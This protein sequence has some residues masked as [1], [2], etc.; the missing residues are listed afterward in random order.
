MVASWCC[1]SGTVERSDDVQLWISVTPKVIDASVWRC[2]RSGRSRTLHLRR[3][4]GDDPRFDGSTGH[5]AVTR[6]LHEAKYSPPHDLATLS[7][8]RPSRGCRQH[9]RRGMEARR[10]TEPWGQHLGPVLRQ[11]HGGPSVRRQA[12]H[13]AP[14]LF[15]VSGVPPGGRRSRGRSRAHLSDPGGRL[16]GPGLR[17][18]GQRRFFPPGL[19]AIR[20][21]DLAGE[22]GSTSSRPRNSSAAWSTAMARAPT[23]SGGPSFGTTR[24]SPPCC[25]PAPTSWKGDRRC[26]AFPRLIPGAGPSSPRMGVGAGCSAPP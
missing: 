15:H 22:A 16:P 12:G 5:K 6:C 1:A 4:R 11:A 23:S 13:C 26:G 17:R 8:L 2:S 24:A 25:R 9:A 20:A 7:P 21:G 3:L 18:G 14:G 19:A 10:G